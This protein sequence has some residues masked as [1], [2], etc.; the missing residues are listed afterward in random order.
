MN[1]H[2]HARRRKFHR[3]GE[4]MGA[5]TCAVCDADRPAGR[6][7]FTVSGPVEIGSA[8]VEVC[9]RDCLASVDATALDRVAE[10]FRTG[11]PIPA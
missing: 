11:D 4:P 7:W 10:R 1:T 2:T 5:P 3:S 9:S 8:T 6:C